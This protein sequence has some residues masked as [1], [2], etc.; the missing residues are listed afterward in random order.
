[1]L[2]SSGSSALQRAAWGV[3]ALVAVTLAAAAPQARAQV[4]LFGDAGPATVQVTSWRDIPFRTVVRQEHDYSCGSAAVATLLTYSYGLPTTEADVFTKMFAIGDQARI[5][6][7]GFSMLDMKNYLVARGLPTD[8]YRLS[9]D[10]LGQM[11]EPVIALVTIG[12]YRHFVV[13]KGMEGDRVLIGDPALGLKSLPKA[14]F[15]KMWNG[16]VLAV[17]EGSGAPEPRFN[18]ASEWSP[19][20]SAPLAVAALPSSTYDALRHLP[21]LYQITPVQLIK[22]P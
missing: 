21:P 10:E 7:V 22:N 16:V 2:A 9:V 6:K 13:V 4:R 18:Q 19:W 15:G 12:P 17:R 5:R 20:A 14:E 3:S 11:D 1:M 8:G